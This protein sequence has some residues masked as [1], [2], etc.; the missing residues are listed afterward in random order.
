[1]SRRDGRHDDVTLF[2]FCWLI[3]SQT[4][5][6]SLDLGSGENTAAASTDSLFSPFLLYVLHS[7]RVVTVDRDGMLVDHTY[8]TQSG[9]F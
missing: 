8:C 7:K 6:A 9:L 2:K 5:S 4:C 1:M 3:S